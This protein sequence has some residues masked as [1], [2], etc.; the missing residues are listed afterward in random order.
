MPVIC[1]VC[2]GTGSVVWEDGL[3]VRPPRSDKEPAEECPACNGYGYE[4]DGTE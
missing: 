3:P 4:P 2:E 1:A